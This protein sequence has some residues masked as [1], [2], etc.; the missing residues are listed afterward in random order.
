MSQ[1]TY[2]VREVNEYIKA[3]LAK[4]PFLSNIV[5]EG[6]VS[7][8]KYHSSGH[9]YI[10]LKEEVVSRGRKVVE[11][12]KVVMWASNVRSMNFNVEVGQKILVTGGVSIYGSGYQVYA[13]KIV[14]AG[15]GLLYERFEQLKRELYEKGLFDE[16]YKQ[17]IPTYALNIGVATASTGAVIQDIR[18]VASRRNKYVNIVLK[19]CT[20]QGS[21]AAVSIVNAIHTLDAMDLDVIIVGRGG[22]SI[23]DLWCFNEEIV[24]QAIFDCKTPIISA[25]GH[26]TDFTIADY[27]ADLR[28][29]T[30]SAAAELAVFEYDV[31]VRQLEYYMDTLKGS[32]QQR[33]DSSKNNLQS[34]R[35][36]LGM[37]MQNN[38]NHKKTM[39]EQTA[40]RL[41]LLSPKSKLAS[42]KTN[43]EQVSQKLNEAV[44][45]KVENSRYQIRLLAEQL[46]SCSPLT[47]MS[48]GFGHISQ[49]GSTIVSVKDVKKSESIKVTLKD[50][51]IDATVNDVEQ[52]DWLNK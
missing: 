26:E 43:V 3:V 34:I 5:V 50:G 16:M 20:V 6:E 17:P 42:Y 30:P 31:F 27:V 23:E 46:H 11:Q 2:S 35:E 21:D 49:K 14:L 22:G 33:I 13:N 4:D 40:K 9:L 12:L 24:A 32:L 52:S 39:L 36:T 51:F 37:V 29:P 28:A 1:K 45:R 25:V 19:P 38:V 48:S 15:A 41:T 47:K 7:S 8:V 10:D 44:N 18:N